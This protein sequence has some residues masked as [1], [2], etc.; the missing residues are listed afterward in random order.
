MSTPT[1]VAPFETYDFLNDSCDGKKELNFE[2]FLYYGDKLRE[3][4]RAF[5]DFILS[6]NKD[7]I[8]T[9]AER[10]VKGTIPAKSKEGRHLLLKVAEYQQNGKM[11]S[12]LKPMRAY[13]LSFLDD[14]KKRINQPNFMRSVSKGRFDTSKRNASL[15]GQ[16]SGVL[17]GKKDHGCKN[18]KRRNSSKYDS[19]RMYDFSAVP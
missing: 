18:K 6:N 4:I 1:V 17:V 5:E 3:R 16:R 12:K 13:E 19:L 7:K 15:N 9:I 10:V 14:M 8:K 11:S 2:D